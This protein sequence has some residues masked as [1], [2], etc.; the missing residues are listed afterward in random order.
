MRGTAKSN[1]DTNTCNAV[2]VVMQGGHAW[3]YESGDGF[4][5]RRCNVCALV[6]EKNTPS[7]G[8]TTYA[9][10]GETVAVIGNHGKLP[11]CR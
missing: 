3:V 7:K 10:G 11:P 5:Y 9:R 2:S 8:K 6:E 1:T 4:L